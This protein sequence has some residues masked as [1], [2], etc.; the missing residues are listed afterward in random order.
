MLGWV[1]QRAYLK[2]LKVEQ[3]FVKGDRVQFP[4]PIVSGRILK[5]VVVEPGDRFTQVRDDRGEIFAVRTD[6]LS[7]EA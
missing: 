2:S 7:A 1:Q 3:Q 5:A 6:N 4:S